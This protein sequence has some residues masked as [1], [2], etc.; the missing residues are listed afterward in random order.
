MC[1]VTSGHHHVL[2]CV[3]VCVRDLATTMKNNNMGA[4]SNLVIPAHY[5][6]HRHHH[7]QSTTPAISS[8]NMCVCGCWSY[9]PLLD[10]GPWLGLVLFPCEHSSC[11]LV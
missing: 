10:L 4:I 3:C 11:V 1:D 2:V 9:W 5:Q 7:H 8:S 6:H